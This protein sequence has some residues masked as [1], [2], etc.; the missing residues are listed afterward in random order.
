MKNKRKN[1]ENRTNRLHLLFKTSVLRPLSFVLCPLSF[2]LCLLSFVSCGERYIPKPRGYYRITIP[3][4]AYTKLDDVEQKRPTDKIIET[5][6]YSFD[7]SDNAYLTPR[8]G[9]DEQYWI[10]ITYPAFQVNIHCTYYPVQKNLRELSDD[11]Q[12]FVYKHAEKANAIPE[13]GFVN[14]E[15]RV[16]G[17]LYELM[18]NTASPYQFYLTDSTQHFF[19]GAVYFSCTPNQDSLA[20]IINYLQQD[21]RHLMETFTWN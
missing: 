9:K 11:A 7:L 14:E 4:T 5:L 19:R 2:I 8:K 17:V 10:D 12:N 16:Y 15:A 21:V 20:P 6:P 13:Q 1:I 3:D 18:G